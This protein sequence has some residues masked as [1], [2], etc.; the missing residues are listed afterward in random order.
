MFTFT[1]EFIW[2]IFL[3]IPFLC[4][5]SDIRP[6]RGRNA[7]HDVCRR[8]VV[9]RP[10]RLRLL[11]LAPSWDLTLH[12]ITAYHHLSSQLCAVMTLQGRPRKDVSLNIR[13][14]G[15]HHP[16][17]L[18]KAVHRAKHP[19]WGRS[20][21]EERLTAESPIPRVCSKTSHYIVTYT[22]HPENQ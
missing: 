20:S 15:G 18:R 22:L 7:G 13:R 17:H 1:A 11:R 5:I 8:F 19:R 14:R 4:G 3:G 12:S 21:T 6:L 16:T 10:P 2:E 9:L